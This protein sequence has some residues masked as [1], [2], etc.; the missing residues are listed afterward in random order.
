M[1]TLLSICVGDLVLSSKPL[2]ASGDSA[3]SF[4]EAYATGSEIRQ[5]CG[6]RHQLWRITIEAVL[7]Q[8]TSVTRQND[9]FVSV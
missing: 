4:R 9:E 8:A 6:Q 5:S 7:H 2:S 1:R 3:T